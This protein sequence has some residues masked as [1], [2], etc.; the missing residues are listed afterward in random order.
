MEQEKLK[1]WNISKK[2]LG[3]FGTL[4]GL[5]LIAKFAFYFMPFFIAG[6]LAIL[7]EP[8][9]KFNMNKLKMSRRKS[10]IIV[11]VITVLLIIGLFVWG[12]TSLV[13]TLLDISK[14]L[15]KYIATVT[16]T[17][18]SGLSEISDDLSN[19]VSEEVLE[20]INSSI[21][22][23]ISSLGSYVQT[24]I[25]KALQLVMSVPTMIV[26]IVITIL[27]L[28]FFTKDRLY[29]INLL[30]FHIPENWLRK[31]RMIKKEIFH[32]LGSYIK[33]YTK[34]IIITTL[35]LII[36]FSILSLIGF[37]FGSIIRLSIVI[38]IID[39]LPILGVGTVLIPWSIWSFITG[40][41]GL[42]VALMIVYLVILVIRQFMEPKFVSNQLGVHPIITLFAMYAGFKLLGFTGLIFGPIALMILRCV[43]AEQIKKGLI[44]SLV[45]E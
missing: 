6:V 40:S 38:A 1:M 16:N 4:I 19:Y 36:A 10:S 11:V 42:G 8:I 29:I 31:G 3:F 32:T 43:Y 12:G 39:I 27:A 14:N 5:Y 25:T 37:K 44:K 23:F 41:I 18:Q 22:N 20:A 28:V 7:I 13:S 30:E 9:I 17:L 34:I 26:N 45:E 24:V 21:V 33:I 2:L 35:E 15:G